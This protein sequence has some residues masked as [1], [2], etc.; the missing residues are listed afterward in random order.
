MLIGDWG[1][2]TGGG[3]DEGD[4]GEITNE[5]SQPSTVNRQPSTI[6]GHIIHVLCQYEKLNK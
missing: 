3:G 2:G 6:N 5:N 1:L 4:E